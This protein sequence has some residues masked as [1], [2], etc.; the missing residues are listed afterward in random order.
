MPV[1]Y[2]ETKRLKVKNLGSHFQGEAR[3]YGIYVAKLASSFAGPRKPSVFLLGGETT[4]RLNKTGQNG[5]GGRN[6]E[7]SFCN[8]INSHFGKNSD[9]T[10]CCIVLME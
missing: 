4:V 1:W 3:G 10:I 7:A 5:R 6:Q 8:S 9:I 2:F